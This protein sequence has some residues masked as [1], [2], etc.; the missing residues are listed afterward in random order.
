MTLF[1]RF[2]GVQPNEA[3]AGFALA[4]ALRSRGGDLERIR[5]LADGARQDSLAAGPTRAEELAEVEA[6]LVDLN[7]Q[8]RR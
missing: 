4:K 7:S 6:W 2:P 5:M 8:P 1:D 3:R